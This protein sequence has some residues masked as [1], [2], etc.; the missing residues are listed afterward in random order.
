MR[1]NQDL[2]FL[3]VG[4]CRSNIEAVHYLTTDPGISGSL[5]AL[6]L[7]ATDPLLSYKDL[8]LIKK[9]K[10]L[11]ITFDSFYLDH[12]EQFVHGLSQLENLQVLKI[13]CCY[14]MTDANALHIIETCSNLST[15]YLPFNSYLTGWF[16]ETFLD[17]RRRGVWA[18]N[19]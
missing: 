11:E 6:R 17:R 12:R 8:L 14:G 16:L 4:D 1:Q 19:P 10:F 7:Y 15:L 5:Q 3:S 13:P 18:G 2:V 9:L